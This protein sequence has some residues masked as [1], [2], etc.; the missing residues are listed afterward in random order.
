MLSSNFRFSSRL[1][2]F[3]VALGRI[4]PAADPFLEPFMRTAVLR[5]GADQ[6]IRIE[7]D[8]TVGEV[9]VGENDQHVGP[10]SL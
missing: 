1:G 3:G 7:G 9:V 5:C 10:G 6:E 2:D 8:A 4:V